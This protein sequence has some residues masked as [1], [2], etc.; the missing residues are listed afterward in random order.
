[1]ENTIL[2]NNFLDYYPIETNNF[3]ANFNKKY[4]F[5]EICSSLESLRDLKV[6]IVGDG[7]VD[8]YHY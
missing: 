6:L 4:D 8:E 7:I 2:F 5:S 3:L 1:M